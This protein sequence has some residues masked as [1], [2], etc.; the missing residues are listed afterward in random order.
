[1]KLSTIDEGTGNPVLLLHSLAQCGE[2]WRP[3]IE[4]L[5]PRARVLA[6]DARG[7]GG[8]PWDGTPFSVEDLADD[9]AA[10]LTELDTGPVAVAGMSMGGCVA[11]AIAANHPA[12]VSRLVLADTT[13]CYGPGRVETWEQRATNA[14]QK[15]RRQQTEFQVDRWFSD[16][17]RERHPDEVRRVVELFVDTDSEAHAQAC[18][19]LGAFDGTGLLAS[20]TCPTLVAVG[21]HDYATPPE[22]ARTIADGVESSDLLVVEEARHFSVF[23]VPEARARVAAHLLGEDG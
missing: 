18:R 1:M 19:A 7:H 10:L 4:A 9:M 14:V 3:L 13:A 22:M 21:E 2:V 11:I 8:S 17:F 20:I 12:L 16:E 6:P 15:P 23:E 5:T